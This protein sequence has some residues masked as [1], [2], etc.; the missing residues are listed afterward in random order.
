[1]P[2]GMGESQKSY[3]LSPGNW[4]LSLNGV[5]A[6]VRKWKTVYLRNPVFGQERLKVAFDFMVCCFPGGACGKEP[7]CQSRRHKK[8]GGD[9]WVEKI[10]WEGNDNPL[11]YSCLENPIY[12]GAWWVQSMGLQRVRH[13]WAQTAL[14]GY[15]Y[16]E[17]TH[18]I[19]RL[20]MTPV[21]WSF[22]YG[23]L[24][25]VSFI[26]FPFKS[27]SSVSETV[28]RG[29]HFSNHL[30]TI[31][32][33][34]PSVSEHRFGLALFLSFFLIYSQGQGMGKSIYKFII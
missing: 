19:F 34:F 20:F 23:H 22:I 30:G 2:R 9:L 21:L 12:R 8:C 11:H 17:V 15:K 5:S 27:V 16:F 18:S 13:D 6:D 24:C 26:L 29:S 1:M 33:S 14:S 31:Q 28:W 25:V 4:I 7:A 32:T 10:P 3:P